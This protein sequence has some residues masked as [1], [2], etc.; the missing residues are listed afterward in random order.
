M[1]QQPETAW[2]TETTTTTVGN[3]YAVTHVEHKTPPLPLHVL[4]YCHE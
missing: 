4:D 2:K 1:Q 3:G